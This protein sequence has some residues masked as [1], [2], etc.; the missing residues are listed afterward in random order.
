MRKR[1]TIGVIAIF[2]IVFVGSS[3]AFA[4]I[5]YGI[6]GGISIMKISASTSSGNSATISSESLV[7]FVGGIYGYSNIANNSIIQGELLYVTKGSKTDYSSLGIDTIENDRIM[8]LEIPILIKYIFVKSSNYNISLYA[9]PSLSLFLNMVYQLT[10]TD[11]DYLASTLGVPTNGTYKDLGLEM[12]NFDFNL[13]F[14]FDAGYEL[15]RGKLKIDLR[16]DLGLT[17]IYKS[18][19]DIT[20]TN[21]GFL[22]MAGYEF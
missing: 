15:S 5:N 10:G 20:Y 16:Y 21:R 19:T 17:D 14:G 12:H 13:C 2:I 11:A 3:I 8:Y 1:R 22:I 18:D 7:G 4:D 9:G 6:K